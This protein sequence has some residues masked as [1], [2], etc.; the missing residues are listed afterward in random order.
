MTLAEGFHDQGSGLSDH[1]MRSLEYPDY[2][3]AGFFVLRSPL[4]P[5]TIAERL[6]SALASAESRPRVTALHQLIRELLQKPAIREALY[7][8]A[9]EILPLL[10]SAFSDGGRA[11]SGN[12]ERLQDTAV[13]YLLRMAYRATPF[14][15]L[16]GCSFGRID[17]RTQLALPSSIHKHVRLDAEIIHELCTS[18]LADTDLVL[19]LPVT[20]NTTLYSHLGEWRYMRSRADNPGEFS[21]TL[22]ALERSYWIDLLLKESSANVPATAHVLRLQ[23]HGY[24]QGQAK[25]FVQSLIDY[26]V[27]ISA[28]MPSVVGR[29]SLDRLQDLI[30]S[31]A[32]ESPWLARIDQMARSIASLNRRG[33][34][35]GPEDYQRHTEIIAAAGVPVRGSRMYQ[36]DMYR[37]GEPLTL[38]AKL[39]NNVRDGAVALMTLSAR[40]AQAERL[41]ALLDAFARQ[42][43]EADVPLLQMFDPVIGLGALR[44]RESLPAASR[45]A[46]QGRT[47]PSLTF[48]QRLLLGLHSTAACEH[49][50]EIVITD[51]ALARVSQHARC[52][53][54]DSFSVLASILAVGPDA[55]PDLPTAPHAHIRL[56]IGGSPASMYGRF[57]HGSDALRSSVQQLAAAEQERRSNVVFA[58]LNFRS[59]S[60]SPNVSWRPLLSAYELTL[61]GPR[62]ATAGA[63][64]DLAD[65][66]VRIE[67]GRFVLWSKQLDKRVVP[68]LSTMQAARTS[69]D[70]PMYVF[71]ASLQG[72]HQ[73]DFAD[74]DLLWG[75]FHR[76]PW[77]PRVRYNHVILGR[78]AWVL[79]IRELQ[80]PRSQQLEALKVLVDKRNIAHRVVLAEAD[81]D[82]PLD[83]GVAWSL[84]LI[85]RALRGTG[86]VQLHE[87]LPTALGTA[88]RGP[89]GPYA[90]EVVLP[91]QSY[92]QPHVSSVPPYRR[93]R[94]VAR[95]V[96]PRVNF[97]PGSEWLYFKVYAPPGAMTRLLVETIGPLCRQLVNEGAAQKWFFLRYADPSEHLRVR[98]HATPARDWPY[99]HARMTDALASTDG[100]LDVRWE[101]GAYERELRRYGGTEAL[102][103]TEHLFHLD[104]ELV[105]SCLSRE[106]RSGYDQARF[107]TAVATLHELLTAL[108]FRTLD[109]KDS[110]IRYALRSF[111]HDRS[112]KARKDRE[113]VAGELHRRTLADLAERLNGSSE[114][115]Q[116][117][118]AM[119]SHAMA[120]RD[121][122]VRSR[123]SSLER[124]AASLL[125]MHCN[126]YFD[127]DI[128]EHEYLAYALLS[129]QYPAITGRTAARQ[130]SAEPQVAHAGND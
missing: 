29:D 4:L 50:H 98:L 107:L 7:L 24:G 91:Y 52:S 42:F 99:V 123:V 28:L 122:L 48:G 36:V 37:P 115:H 47:D 64:L 75:P 72:E 34:D 49:R 90:N 120:A 124:W 19:S 40:S 27:L 8:A 73:C 16:A 23:R 61:I 79:D 113:I 127:Q 56:V 41:Q 102:N 119:H 9:P 35:V 101:L 33:A 76:L 59:G 66:Y 13:R 45:L 58:E 129:R 103:H 118:R 30:R 88:L 67:D 53:P 108:Q 92:Q 121:A 74:Q 111:E 3:P 22:E 68:R 96:T 116:W 54:P 18:M 87:C 31:H 128:G 1:A 106:E 82:L 77:L 32:P 10:D 110:V 84:H 6:F 11:G 78:E 20:P 83:L 81:H 57:L 70:L 43:G 55:P 89:D 85:L 95:E 69:R 114:D 17:N 125:H 5:L 25:A 65:L 109:E 21:F 126:R 94:V 112:G 15:T 130:S 105:L 14:G 62:D 46:E 100:A 39:S 12:A 51:E 38:S 97:L 2:V 26:Q 117:F 71:L 63:S 86:T 60:R 44:D 93:Q 104:S 80:G